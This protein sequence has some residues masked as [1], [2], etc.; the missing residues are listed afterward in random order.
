MKLHITKIKQRVIMSAASSVPHVHYTQ[1][2]WRSTP[3]KRPEQKGPL[4]SL[5]SKILIPAQEFC[6]NRK[7]SVSVLKNYESEITNKL[8]H[9]VDKNN[10]LDFVV[11]YH[12]VSQIKNISKC[13]LYFNPNG[14]SVAGFFAGCKQTNSAKMLDQD[15]LNNFMYMPAYLSKLENCGVVLFDLRGCGLNRRPF[16]HCGIFSDTVSYFQPDANTIRE[17]GITMLNKVT[18]MFGSVKIWGTS[19]GGGVGT[20]ALSH[21]LEAHPL[22]AHRFTLT[23]HN[24]FNTTAKC[25]TQNGLLKMMISGLDVN[26]KAGKAMN[27]VVRHGVPVTV[28]THLNDSMIRDGSRMLN[29]F[30]KRYPSGILPPNVTLLQAETDNHMG[31]DYSI[32][33][34]LFRRAFTELAKNFI[35]RENQHNLVFAGVGDDPSDI[36]IYDQKGKFWNVRNY[37]PYSVEFFLSMLLQRSDFPHGQEFPSLGLAV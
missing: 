1:E 12:D 21:Y 3:L 30:Q 31:I 4:S 7:S 34:E 33:R 13:V 37:S 10:A 32:S 26:V 23:N 19:M 24:S 17:D 15:L 35:T 36:G 29:H 11:Y 2:S 28:I 9:Y 6:L 27:V 8:V 22:E 16:A 14:V 20:V 25:V 18:T 5:A